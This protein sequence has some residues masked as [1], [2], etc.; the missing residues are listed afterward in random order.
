MGKTQLFLLAALGH[1]FTAA[2]P[3]LSDSSLSPTLAGDEAQRAAEEAVQKTEKE[4]A[5]GEGEV[6]RWK[7]TV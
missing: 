6:D 5:P 4:E 1:R 3:V 2:A 7:R